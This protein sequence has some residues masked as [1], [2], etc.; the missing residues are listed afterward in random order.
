MRSPTCGASFALAPSL[1]WRRERPWAPLV[2]VL[3]PHLGLVQI[4]P[5]W[6]VEAIVH[7]LIPA[8]ASGWVRAG[9]DEFLRTYVTPRGRVA[10][11]ATARQIYLEEPHGAK[12]FWTRLAGLRPPALFVWGQ[13]DRLVPLAFAAHVRHTLPSARHVELDCGH[14]PQIERPAETHAA[15]AEFLQEDRSSAGA[16]RR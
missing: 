13:H 12:G 3:S 7:R 9:V 16:A 11:Y 2:R 5:R 8:A 14:V 1:D 6:A 4:T 15:I 10:F